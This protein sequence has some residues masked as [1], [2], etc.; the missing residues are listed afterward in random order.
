MVELQERIRLQRVRHIVDSY[1]LDQTDD[2]VEKLAFASVFAVVLRRFPPELVEL[3]MVEILVQ[4][5]S[6]I[7]MPRGM[8]FLKPVCRRLRYWREHPVISRV[9]PEQFQLITGLE[10]LPVV[11]GV[12]PEGAAHCS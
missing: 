6:I 11:R 8:G 5:W 7:P 10:P 9:G 3:A 1:H 2:E 12:P 4:H